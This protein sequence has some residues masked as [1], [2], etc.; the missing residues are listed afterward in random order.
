MR[1]IAIQRL[2][3]GLLQLAASQ[4]LHNALRS[5]R[6][7]RG[8]LEEVFIPGKLCLN[9]FNQ[10]RPLGFWDG[11]AC[12][13]VE[14]C[15]LLY[16][17]A[18]SAALDHANGSIGFVGG[19]AGQCLSNRHAPT[20]EAS[21]RFGNPKIKILII[22]W[23]NIEES[24]VPH[25]QNQGLTDLK[26]AKLPQI[27]VKMRKM[28]YEER[29]QIEAL[30][31]SGLSTG[32]IAKQMGHDRT[33]IYREIRRNSG[34]PGYRHKQAQEKTKTRHRAASSVSWRFTPVR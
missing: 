18:N 21:K 22:L 17:A 15:L 8:G 13:E 34:K 11:K 23:P 12:S 33:T 31:K 2:I 32:L 26:S 5:C 14:E 9:D 19:A 10:F 6:Q 4:S 1:G 7:F 25:S 27:N 30:K 24:A 20:L 29:C 28:G 16:L 3:R